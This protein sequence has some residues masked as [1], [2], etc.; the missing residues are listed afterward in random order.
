MGFQSITVKGIEADDIAYWLVN[1]KLENESGYLISE[2]RDWTQSINSNWSLYR[3]LSDETITF[4]NFNTAYE[5]KDIRTCFIIKKSFEGDTSDFIQGCNGV[6]KKKGPIYAKKLLANEPLN[7]KLK[8]DQSIQE[9]IDSGK[10]AKNME[11][12]DFQMLSRGERR[13]INIAYDESLKIVEPQNFITWLNLATE[14]DS[15][16]MINFGGEYLEGW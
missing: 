11:L 10:L 12:I 9:F 14:I 6:G 5:S 15:N 7:L 2:D 13:K 1:T 4:E 8:T 3:P 16:N